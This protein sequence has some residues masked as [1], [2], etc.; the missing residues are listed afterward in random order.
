LSV[1]ETGGRQEGV[2]EEGFVYGKGGVEYAL[3]CTTEKE[4]WKG[5]CTLEKGA[6]YI[7]ETYTSLA[8]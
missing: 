2:G 8:E 3:V 7:G 6:K 4:T 1:G 5:Y